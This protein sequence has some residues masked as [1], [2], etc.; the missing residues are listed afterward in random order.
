MPS[1]NTGGSSRPGGFAVL[2][3]RS[4]M[5]KTK[6]PAS[7]QKRFAD[8][9]LSEKKKYVQRQNGQQR[10][11]SSL[12]LTSVCVTLTSLV[13]VV[14]GIIKGSTTQDTTGAGERPHN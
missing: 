10:H 7:E 5:H 2:S 3:T 9:K 1:Q 12:I 11:R 4:I 8:D 13:S 14:K 6:P